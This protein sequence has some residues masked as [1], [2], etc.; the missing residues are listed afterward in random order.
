MGT[1]ERREERKKTT[2]FVSCFKCTDKV[3]P[4]EAEAHDTENGATIYLCGGDC[5]ADFWLSPAPQVY[6][7][8][9]GE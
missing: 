6:C 8:V 9:G 3:Q 2:T 7:V 5:I 4:E 1:L